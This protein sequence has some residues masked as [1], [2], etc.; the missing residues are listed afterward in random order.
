MSGC[1]SADHGGLITHNQILLIA[2][3]CCNLRLGAIYTVTS[4]FDMARSHGAGGGHSD[5]ILS[6]CLAS[7]SPAPLALV[8]GV[9]GGKG[10]ETVKRRESEGTESI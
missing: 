8:S 9:S 6:L 5:R 2:S 7:L 1:K 10:E 3:L 4:S